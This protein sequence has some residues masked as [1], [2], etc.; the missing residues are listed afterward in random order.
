MAWVELQVWDS[1]SDFNTRA[2]VRIMADSMEEV[3]VMADAYI[4]ECRQAE[5]HIEWDA[6]L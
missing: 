3:F 4:E 6:Q 5:P 2:K 1:S